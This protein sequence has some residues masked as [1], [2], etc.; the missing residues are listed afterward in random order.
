MI[1]FKDLLQSRIVLEIKPAWFYLVAEKRGLILEGNMHRSNDDDY[2][3]GKDN[4][5]F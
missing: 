2:Q 4:V 3:R 1:A 5:L